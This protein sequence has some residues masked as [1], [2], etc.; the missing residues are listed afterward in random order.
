MKTIE[1]KGQFLVL[2]LMLL[3]ATGA[4]GQW[5]NEDTTIFYRKAYVT[6]TLKK[7]TYPP[8]SRPL[9]PIIY[10]KEVR[11]EQNKDKI[12]SAIKIIKK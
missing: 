12:T 4:M 9:P 11:Y 6:G 5:A 8:S 7:D 3:T 10:V 2:M 1:K